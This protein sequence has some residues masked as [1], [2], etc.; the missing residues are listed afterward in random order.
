VWTLGCAEFEFIVERVHNRRQHAG[1]Y[2]SGM[3]SRDLLMGEPARLDVSRETGE[4][5]SPVDTGRTTY[6]PA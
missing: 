2:L 5:G 3:F 1:T 6:G 4:G